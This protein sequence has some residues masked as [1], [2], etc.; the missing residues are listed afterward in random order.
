[1]K[2]NS[3]PTDGVPIISRETTSQIYN[4]RV[5][6]RKQIRDYI[7]DSKKMGA[8]IFHKRSP[9]MWGWGS[10][11]SYQYGDG[12]PKNGGPQNFM[13]LAF[14]IRFI[15]KHEEQILNKLPVPP[16]CSVQGIG[17]FSSICRKTE[18]NCMP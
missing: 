1:M 15:L 18:R 11:I 9:F 5:P 6:Q 3:L 2:Y 10:L 17:P 14:I 12:V 13:T 4:I 16:G 7:R 8:P